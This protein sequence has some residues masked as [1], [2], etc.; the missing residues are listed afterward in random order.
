[1]HAFQAGIFGGPPSR[2]P[3]FNRPLAVLRFLP[4]AG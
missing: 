4:L 2:A 1:L 3:V